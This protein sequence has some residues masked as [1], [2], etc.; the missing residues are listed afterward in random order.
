MS[1]RPFPFLGSVLALALFAPFSALAAPDETEVKA[2]REAAERYRERM[3]EFQGD[4][5]SIVD[6][7]E[8]E[9]KSRI[10]SVFGSAMGRAEDDGNSLRRAAITKLESFLSRYPGTRYSADMKFRLADLYFED[11]ELDFIA[12]MQ[13]YNQLEDQLA[14]NPSATLPE[15]P[16]KDYRRS[17]GLYRDIV[18]NHTDYEFTPDTLYMLGWCLSA[19]NAAQ[20]DEEA[21]RDVY[22][23]IVQGH[24]KSG[25]ANDANMRLGEY[26]FDLPV[27]PADR[28]LNVRT[29]IAYYE[30]VKSDGPTGRNY[31]EAIY[32]LGWS[33]YKL[34][35]YDRALAYLV[36]L[37]DY[38]DEQFAKTGR[39]SD[40]RKEAV[41][42]LAISYSDMADRFSKKPVDVAS[43]HLSKLGEKKWE[44][45]AV[46]RLAQILLVQAKFDE[47]IQT[48]TYL[49]E[50]W[51]L[52]P[53][54]PIYQYE[55]AVIYGQKMPI[56]RPD[57]AAAA[58][59]KIGER[60]VEGQP[61]YGANK[62]NPDAIA[63]ARG[64]VESSLADVATDILLRA[65]ESG[66][67]EDYALAA[68]KYRDFL[69]KYPFADD[70]DEYQ[71]YLALSLYSSNQF[72]AAEKEY[73]QILK[74]AA[75]PFREGSR[76]QLM[77][78]REQIV[79]SRYGKLE[80][81]PSGAIVSG[82][83]TSAAGKQ[84]TQYLISDEQKSFVASADDLIDREFQSP[85]WAPLLEKSRPAL[86]YL[87]AQIYFNHGQY[88]E[89]RKRFDSVI[90]R[91]PGTPER[92]Y[93]VDLL[94][95][96][97]QNE[98]NIAKVKELLE[99]YTVRD[100]AVPTGVAT[101]RAAKLEQASL[102]LCLDLAT[103]G[104]RAESAACYQKFMVDFQRS[105]YRNV[106]LYNAAN[107]LDLSGQT[108]KANALFEQ[109]I[110]EFP[111]DERAKSLYYRIAQGYSAVLELDKAVRYFEALPNIDRNHPDAAASLYNA[112][113]LRTGMG[114]H[115]GAAKAYEKYASL[116]NVAD[117][118]VIYWRA[119]EQWSLVS[120]RDAADFYDRYLKRF[121]SQNPS[122]T[123]EALY[124]LAKVAEVKGDKTKIRQRWAEIET[125]FK[126]NVARGITSDAR[127]LAAEGPL[128]TLIAEF[129]VFSKYKYGTSEAANVE[130]VLKKKPEE[131]KA[132]DDSAAALIQTYQDYESASAALYYQGMSFLVYADLVYNV[133]P[134]S[135]LS[136][137]EVAIYQE[138]LDPFRLAAEDRGKAKLIAVVE[139]AKSQQRWCAW[140]GKALE[141]LH[142][143]YPTEFPSERQEG[144]G[145]FPTGLVQPAGPVS[146]DPTTKGG[147]Q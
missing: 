33:H 81:V 42:Y 116:P 37:L 120:E 32:K 1:L 135:G 147:A 86:S 76:F 87:A 15:P 20:Y 130:L 143:R 51:P 70:Y 62:T 138:Q 24:P 74:N 128:N 83:V 17:V 80:T 78:S 7:T 23:A 110:N 93:A 35:E 4:V 105:T 96:S 63:A 119:G 47:S 49:Q 6:A 102:Q 56:R 21:A 46:E 137:D 113:F 36:Q 91:Y 5:R 106:A 92:E 59:A 10:T 142:D 38:S 3:G 126:E 14:A 55:I 39:V 133:P 136:D 122:H 2:F 114:D 131:R 18:A 111:T 88:D 115:T 146:V 13:E 141:A 12:R 26:Y 134:P 45:D 117:A 82:V 41:E 112:A 97:H 67:I 101:S 104:Q 123:I 99:K 100:D 64:F 145:S 54:N 16:S 103:A 72:E 121:G 85:D 34:N 75:S 79:L 9:E 140:N 60:Y 31:D 8:S 107:N 11:A 84:I 43:A 28:T 127:K 61:W 53:Q 66:K 52:H 124:R 44:H 95:Q 73:G 132:F 30:A 69:A 90:A 58:L 129:D 27:N 144:R 109:Y 125:T 19:T 108:A 89:A 68:Q 77:K 25:F 118:E 98:G 29:A 65:K 48:Y 57:D 50:R 94:V 139:Y 71:W 40:M 22:I